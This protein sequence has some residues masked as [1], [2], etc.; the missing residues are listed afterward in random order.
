MLCNQDIKTM[1]L[2]CQ[3]IKLEMIFGTFCMIYSFTFLTGVYAVM[4]QDKFITC[5]AALFGNFY[6]ELPSIMVGSH[7]G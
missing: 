2:S 7:H 6:I 1:P 5:F 4:S 3:M